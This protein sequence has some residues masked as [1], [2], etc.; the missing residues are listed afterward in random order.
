MG[1]SVWA[2]LETH[3]NQAAIRNQNLVRWCDYLAVPLAY[4]HSPNPGAD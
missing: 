2:K 3:A 1:Y 4:E